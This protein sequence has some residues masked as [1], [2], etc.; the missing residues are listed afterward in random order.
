MATDHKHIDAPTGRVRAY[1]KDI[2]DEFCPKC[3]RPTH[4]MVK[5]LAVVGVNKQ[6]QREMKSATMLEIGHCAL[7]EGCQTRR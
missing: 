1:F 6:C 3:R 7:C 2:L 4:A 5:C